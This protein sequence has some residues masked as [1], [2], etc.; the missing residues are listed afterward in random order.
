MAT[1]LKP[2]SDSLPPAKAF[3][4]AWDF[5]PTAVPCCL[6]ATLFWPMAREA[7][8]VAL[9]SLYGKPPGF[10][11]I[12][13]R[14]MSI[15]V[16][17]WVNLMPLPA[18]KLTVVPSVINAVFPVAVASFS[19]VVEYTL[20]STPS[21]QPVSEPSS[22]AMTPGTMPAQR[23]ITARDAASCFPLRDRVD[24]T[25]PSLFA[26][27]DTTIQQCFTLLQITL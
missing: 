22:A 21:F 17:Y 5:Q 20:L 14:P 18:N 16:P 26:N 4:P 19:V 2:A 12:N 7:A 24:I 10:I 27:S 25:F 15:D 11:S 6:S 13:L 1:E 8:P 23:A 3:S 9:A